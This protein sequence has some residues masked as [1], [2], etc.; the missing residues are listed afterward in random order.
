MT[1]SSGCA[2]NITVVESNGWNGS[3]G[4]KRVPIS[5][6]QKFGRESCMH[7]DAKMSVDVPAVVG[8]AGR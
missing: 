1:S 3:I 5:V 2:T 8:I 7:C 6:E 4:L